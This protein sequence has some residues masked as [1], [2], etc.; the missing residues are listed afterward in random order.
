MIAWSIEA[1][2]K[3]QLFNKIIVSTDD[4]EIA[5]IA[6]Q[7]GAE[8]PFIRPKD[9][10]DDLTPTVPVIAHAISEIEKLWGE[11]KFVCCLYAAAPFVNPENIIQALDL[12]QQS[13]AKY[14]VPV[15]TFPFP[16]QRSF[17]LRS[18]Q[19]LEMFYPEY[20]STR[21]Q[22]LPEAFHDVGQFYWGRRSS[23]LDGHSIFSPG[24]EFILVPRSRVQD[25]DTVEDWDRAEI[26]FRLIEEEFNK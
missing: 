8:V 12:L 5:M 20:A 22:D 24:A 2:K 3:T 6:E 19:T 26:I 7:F 23:W 4:D 1:A 16:I 17:K 25:I 15:T 14:A 9:L 10:S 21:S 13:K 18:D 11:H